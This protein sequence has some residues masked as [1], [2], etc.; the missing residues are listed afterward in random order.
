LDGSNFIVL[1]A[2]QRSGTNPLRDVLAAHPE[3]FCTPEVFHNE[4]SASAELEVETNFFNFLEQHPLGTV[5]RSISMEV[6]GRMF[7]DFLEYL[8]CFTDKHY[9]LVDVKYNSTHHLDGPWREISA[10]PDLFRF[11]KHHRVRVLN[12]TRRNSLRSHLSLLKA[13]LTSTWTVE[14]G[15]S[16]PP[17]D[18]QVIVDTAQMLHVLRV[19]RGEDELIRRVFE[20]YGQY[21]TFDYED[22]FPELGGP[23]S[24][25]VLDRISTW[26]GVDPEFSATPKYRKQSALTLEETIANYDEVVHAL[27]G[28]GLESCL[29]DERMYRARRANQP[30]D[31]R[32]GRPKGSRARGKDAPR[33]RSGRAG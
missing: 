17:P 12:L 32:A 23:S 28:T 18:Q 6:Q 11:I 16:G 14:S 30:H 3:I 5:K 19:W 9:I 25:A 33:R 26:L 29:E 20:D 15:A 21:L 2:R 24:P 10:Q 22:L 8:R 4:P 31:P 27:A 13:N 1:L 7:L